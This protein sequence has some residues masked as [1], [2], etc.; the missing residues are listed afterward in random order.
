M[1]TGNETAAIC[2][3]FCGTCPSYPNE[4][5]GCLST[6]VA[7]GCDT[8]GNGFRSC[9]AGHNVARC[10]E[11]SGFPCNRLEE[12][13]K[14]HIVNGICHHEHVID[15]L[16]RM[17]KIGV[18]VWVAEQERAHTC[19]GCGFLIPWFERSCTRCKG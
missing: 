13:S 18:P 12:F 14:R 19:P 11:C 10:F 16:K 4:C 6:H 2:G 1:K 17:G 15:D 5:G 9:A 7:P 8:C 3:L